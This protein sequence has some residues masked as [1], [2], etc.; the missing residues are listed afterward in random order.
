MID[1]HRF[2][3][4]ASRTRAFFGVD[5]QKKVDVRRCLS[6]GRIRTVN[7]EKALYFEVVAPAD[8]EAND[9][10]GVDALTINSSDAV[11][12]KLTS[13]VHAG[14]LAG[15][16]TDIFT[17]A[18]ELGHGVF[19]HP[20]VA[21]ARTT[22]TGGYTPISAGVWRYEK[23][24]NRFASFFLVDEQLADD[25]TSSEALAR[26]FGVSLA[27][28][29]RWFAE[30]QSGETR[31]RV[32]GG[33]QELLRKLE[34]RSSEQSVAVSAHTV[35]SASRPAMSPRREQ[36]GRLRCYCT[37]GTLI[38]TLSGKFQCDACGRM[39][40]IPEGDW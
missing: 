7:G 13:Q 19:C 18:H 32:S 6:F 30:R 15:R 9:M 8:I 39:S 23:E 40:E 3:I 28:A 33:F 34:T 16:A 26:C 4:E 12:I 36:T 5:G 31:A 2:R 1:D 17:L 21:L 27:F 14:I 22:R 24:A 35:A 37:H 29:E 10:R 11:R 25:C 38:P 20:R